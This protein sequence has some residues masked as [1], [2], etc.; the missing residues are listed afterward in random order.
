MPVIAPFPDL[1]APTGPYAVATR[2]TTWIDSTREE[3]YTL[4]PDWRKLTIQVWYPTAQNQDA[5]LPY[6]DD[7]GLRIPALAKQL[8]LPVSVISHVRL[9]HTHASRRASVTIDSLNFPVL[10][11][12][13]GLSGM[14]FQN[15]AL[16]EELA[17]QGYVIL[18]PDHSYDANIAIFADG[19]FASY[20]AGKR[21][22]L[23]GNHLEALD[24]N[25]LTIRVLDLRFILDQL[26][27]RSN[28]AF[29]KGIPYDLGH[30]GVMGHSLGGATVLTLLATDPRVQ[31]G[32]ILD[33]WYLPLSDSLLAAGI[34]QPQFN[35]GQSA[36]PDPS[37]YQRMDQL[38][39]NS[40]APVYKL[41]IPH[42]QH[43]D[44]TDMPLFSPFSRLIG[45]TSIPD[46]LWLNQM[47]RQSA[48]AFFDVYLKAA[49]PSK[50][51]TLL[52]TE[53]AVN[54]YIFIP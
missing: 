20:R 36:W 9:V 49:P 29:L 21:R 13:H 50:L 3:T 27:R 11:F 41:L 42:T 46:P 32:F 23:K 22:V 26:S 4:E 33:G 53:S 31:A 6:I 7:P 28:E 2:T 35:L 48:V 52:Q 30:V 1:P 34:D 18:A 38:L 25:Q 17:S 16:L 12:S 5:A 43:T 54:A 8:R 39:A 40:H 15:T 51:V 45:Y 47:I 10:L 24:R 19:T 37:N 14:R 44:F